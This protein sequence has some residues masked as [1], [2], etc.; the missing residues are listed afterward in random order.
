MKQKTFEDYYVGWKTRHSLGRTI[1]E[2]DEVWLCNLVTS[3]NQL[4]FNKDYAS[5]TQFGQSAVNA[6]VTNAIVTGLTTDEFGQNC[7]V[8]RWTYIRMPKPLFVGETVYAESEVLKTEAGQEQEPFGTVT[9]RTC[10]ITENGKVVIDM[11]RDILI[12][13]KAFPE[14]ALYR[15]LN[16]E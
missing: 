13:K 1:I 4:H 9:V 5:R 16:V 10:G 14:I 7:R 3:P 2:T 11:E 15:N 6:P 12:Q 8:K